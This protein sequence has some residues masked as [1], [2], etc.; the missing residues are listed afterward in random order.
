MPSNVEQP[1]GLS[2]AGL[3]VIIGLIIALLGTGALLLGR[4]RA[5]VRDAVRLMDMT[6]FSAAMHLIYS[7][8]GSYATAAQGCSAKGA[9]MSSC[10]VSPLLA[11]I[12]QLKDP[13][14]FTY[15]VAD[16]PDAD[17]YAIV[18][19]L[20]QGYQSYAAGQHVLTQDGIR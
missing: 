18:F 5:R 1:R 2:L 14:R 6:Q 13:S 3:L 7:E 11:S 17:S 4:E 15:L 19:T 16:V 8:K 12:N 9:L 20:E 10:A